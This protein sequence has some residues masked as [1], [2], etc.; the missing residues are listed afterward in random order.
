MNLE[1]LIVGIGMEYV[2]VKDLGVVVICKYFGVVECVEVCEVW[3]CRYVEVD[4]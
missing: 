4:G 1:F 2:L 3:V